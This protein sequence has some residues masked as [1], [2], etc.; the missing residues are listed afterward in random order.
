MDN[1]INFDHLSNSTQR[2]ILESAI[3]IFSQKG[4]SGSTTKEIAK[5]AGVS[6]GTIFRY[7][8]TKK[9]LL[10]ALISP[11]MVKTIT[12]LFMDI[13][14]KS[15][16]EILRNFLKSNT[17]SIYDNRD[18]L[19][20]VAY[21]ALFHPEIKTALFDEII[22]NKA[23]ILNKYFEKA[24]KL[25]KMKDI[26]PDTA[27]QVLFGLLIGFSIWKFQFKANDEQE[28]DEE[29]VFDDIIEIFFYGIRKE[30]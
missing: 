7:F 10:L 8:E 23:V 1:T 25:G 21:E 3:K 18:L 30:N 15:D 4:F 11:A 14:G 20:I 2:K 13:H 12:E 6:E 19:K 17:E 27:T 9:E 24:Q 29:N 22:K 26:D 5:D 16:E 28:Y